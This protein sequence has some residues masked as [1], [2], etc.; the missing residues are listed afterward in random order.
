[1]DSKVELGSQGTTESQWDKTEK[2][3]ARLKRDL[4]ATIDAHATMNGIHQFQMVDRLLRWALE[5]VNLET[6][7]LPKTH[8]TTNRSQEEILSSSNLWKPRT[9][10][11]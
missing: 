6:S 10:R 9:R 8:P 11:K 5:D 2:I 4:I 3:Q 7:Q 1:M